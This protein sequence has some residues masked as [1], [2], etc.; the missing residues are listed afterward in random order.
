MV[1]HGTKVALHLKEE[2]VRMKKCLG[3]KNQAKAY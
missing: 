2:N 1:L 3:E